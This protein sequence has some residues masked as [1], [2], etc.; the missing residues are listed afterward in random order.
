MFE[1]CLRN[2]EARFLS[3][4]FLYYGM[5][6]HMLSVAVLRRA[7]RP[8]GAERESCLRNYGSLCKAAFFVSIR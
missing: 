6:L 5:T 7:K 1:S 3:G 8:H 2:S 4:F